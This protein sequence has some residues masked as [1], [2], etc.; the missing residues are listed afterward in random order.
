MKNLS[1]EEFQ[2]RVEAVNR[3]AAIFGELTEQ[4]ITRAFKAYQMIFA[5][6]EREIFITNMDNPDYMGKY[7]R[8]KC[9]CGFDMKFRVVPD[10]PD[11]IKTQLVCSNPE[12]DIV[13]DSP[14]TM[15]EWRKILEV[16][17]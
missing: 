13:L 17:R 15:D 1:R 10:N 2:D 5:E 6:R 16:K 11:N 8:P 3:A 7:E 9:E 4:N 12:C 14:Y